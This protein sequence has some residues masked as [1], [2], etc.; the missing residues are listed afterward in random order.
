MAT[1]FCYYA[2][3]FRLRLIFGSIMMT[4]LVAV[5]CIDDWLD[6][7]ELRDTWLQP[8]FP[9]RPYLP[10]GLLLLAIFLVLITLAG[11]EL[12]L[13]FRAKAVEANTSMMVIAGGVGLVLVYIVPYKLTSQQTVGII[14]T[15][16]VLVFLA[17]LVQYSWKGRTEGAMQ[18]GG[19]MMFALLYL[20]VLPGFYLAI[21]RWHSA[22]IIA[23]IL[24][25]AKSCDIGAYAIGTLIG[26]HR[27][28]PWLSPGKTWEGLLAGVA[29]SATVAVLLA[30]ILNWM[31]LAGFY[32]TTRTFNHRPYPLVPAALAGGLIGLVGQFGDMCASLLKRDAGMKNSGSSVPGFGGI[33]DVIDS[34]IIVA[35]LAYWMLE[36]SRISD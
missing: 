3:V 1:S 9:N 33:L 35:P 6:R 10:A 23:S 27:L 14:A 8:V 2:I 4:S 36:L 29:L 19:A 13:M 25:V 15:L 11:R 22:W 30:T 20:G 34:P 12:C 5:F 7:I 32:D 16:M 24:V 18:V 28:L 26:R 21:R 17:T 31:Q